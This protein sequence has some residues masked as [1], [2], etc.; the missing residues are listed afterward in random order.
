MM[1]VENAGTIS[2]GTSLTYGSKIHGIRAKHPPGTFNLI[3]TTTQSPLATCMV[4]NH[5][6]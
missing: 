4:S 6:R 2:Q 3:V 5:G 1:N